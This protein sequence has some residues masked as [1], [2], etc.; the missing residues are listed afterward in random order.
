MSR[1]TDV[2]D[3][4][5]KEAEEHDLLVESHG[6]KWKVTNLATGLVKFLPKNGA[7]RS[8]DNFRTQLRSLRPAPSL[9]LA[10]TERTD[11]MPR[12]T[13]WKVEDLLAAAHMQGLRPYVSGG[14]LHVHGDL[15]AQPVAEMLHARE[16]EVIAHLTRSHTNPTNPSEGNQA[17]PKIVETARIDRTG[18][19]RNIAGDAEALWELL[20]DEARKQG[21]RHGT[22]AG[23][24]GVLWTGALIHIVQE[25]GKDWDDAHVQEVR[26]YLNRTEHTHC[27]RPKAKPPVWWLAN[28]WNDGGLTVTRSA[29][30]GDLERVEPQQP[31]PEPEP[32]AAPGS[33]LA[34]LR[35]LDQRITAAEQRAVDAEKALD[36]ARGERSDLLTELDEVRAELGQAV[37]D[38]DK[39]QAELDLIN[40]MLG[41]LGLGSTPVAEPLP[42]RRS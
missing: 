1:A 42:T 32:A 6:R 21:D 26:Q 2:K 17:V 24:P 27:Q 40:T 20:R 30:K 35:A 16:A 5:D 19:V 36:Q 41:K 9:M 38:R 22:N 11:S 4:L 31:E 12:D 7:G 13:W 8:L 23:V 18:P 39:A 29:K 28:A 37:A 33:A 25:I 3:L 10:A 15:D 14:I 34:A